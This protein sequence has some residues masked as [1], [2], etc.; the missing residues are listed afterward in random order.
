MCSVVNRRSSTIAAATSA[1][2]S[3]IA[4]PASNPVEG[5]REVFGFLTT[6]ANAVVAPVHAK[7]MPVIL[8]TEEEFDLWLRAPWHEAAVLQRP[9]LTEPLQVVATGTKSDEELGQTP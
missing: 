8:T 3:T 4:G 2:G 9:L 5:E 1:F 7:A 6:E